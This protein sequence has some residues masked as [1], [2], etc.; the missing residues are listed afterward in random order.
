[1]PRKKAAEGSH[2]APKKIFRRRTVEPAIDEEE[3]LRLKRIL[4]QEEHLESDMRRDMEDIIRN[5]DRALSK[6]LKYMEERNKRLL[7]WIGVTFFMLVIVIFWVAGLKATTSPIFQEK[8]DDRELDIKQ[9]KDDLTRVMD[10]VINGIDD[11]KQQANQIN[12]SGTPTSSQAFPSVPA[13]R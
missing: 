8:S 13:G 2:T 4:A 3:I 12:A 9:T 6:Q 1:M 5:R 10:R 11:L 7:M